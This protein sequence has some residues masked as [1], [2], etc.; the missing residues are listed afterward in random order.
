[1]DLY[2]MGGE[3]MKATEAKKQRLKG[4]LYEVEG[5]APSSGGPGLA[6][7]WDDMAFMRGKAT[8]LREAIRIVWEMDDTDLIFKEGDR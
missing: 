1:M 7:D 4:K 5:A 2:I 6:L 8:G 3:D